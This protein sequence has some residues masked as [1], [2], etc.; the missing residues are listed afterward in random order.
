MLL[1]PIVMKTVSIFENAKSTKYRL[2]DQLL[3]G[4][5]MGKSLKVFQIVRLYSPSDFLCTRH[6]KTADSAT[7]AF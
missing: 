1:S 7:K 6:N 2:F 3:F 5:P 4:F